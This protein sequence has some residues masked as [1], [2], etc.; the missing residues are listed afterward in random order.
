[1]KDEYN[2]TLK[3]NNALKKTLISLGKSSM[4]EMLEEV[5]IECDEKEM[6]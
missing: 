1:M 3:L 6:N 4:I 2:K 5:A